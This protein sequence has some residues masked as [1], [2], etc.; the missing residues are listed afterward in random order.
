MHEEGMLTV[1]AITKAGEAAGLDGPT[2][3]H[4]VHRYH[5]IGLVQAAGVTVVNHAEARAFS[6]QQ[7]AVALVLTAVAQWGGIVDT[8]RLKGLADHLLTDPGDGVPLIDR[9][10]DDIENDGFVSATVAPGGA[11]KTSLTITEALSMAMIA[12]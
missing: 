11:A 12:P 8:P 5:R 3:R 9:V 7:A 1:T 4:A 6:R 2:T 10:L